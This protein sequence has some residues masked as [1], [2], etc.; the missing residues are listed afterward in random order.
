MAAEAQ[1]VERRKEAV[2]DPLLMEEI[3]RTLAGR[4]RHIRLVGRLRELYR[5][6]T[7]SQSSLIV[8]SWMAW[9]VVLDLM[10]VALNYSY[11]APELATQALLPCAIIVLGALSVITIYRGRGWL[12]LQDCALVA[13]T[14]VILFAIT[15][16]GV[17]AGPEFYE[18]YSNIMIFVAITAIVIFPIP[19]AWTWAMAATAL[20]LH[21]AMQLCSPLVDNVSAIAMSAF[22]GVGLVGTVFA[23]R[24]VTIITQKSFLLSLR[25]LK[26][27]S[28]LAVANARLETLARTDPL[29]GVANRR[30]MTETMEGLWHDGTTSRRVG[31]LMCDVDHFKGLNDALGHLEGDRCLR[32]VANVIR[33]CI[34][35]GLDHVARYGGEEFLVL[36]TDVDAFD[37]RLAAERICR[38]MEAALLP[39]PGS[40]VSRYVTVSIGVST[41]HPDHPVSAERL[42]RQAD[43]ALYL[44]KSRGRNRV[45]AYDEVLGT[46]DVSIPPSA[47]I[48]RG[49]RG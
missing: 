37:A 40:G 42:Q 44:A 46:T 2:E 33:D 13:G 8:R 25:D 28:D 11:L 43:E 19:L 4:T 14:F 9:V 32:E 39:N 31:I 15:L 38:T 23:R 18:R 41:D 21:L 5:E 36:L 7:F 27:V 3:D 30:W 1:A 35:P 12:V 10:G 22:F 49:G 6:R 24:S 48:E 16:V 47:R 34:R 45:V 29:T 26:R 20:F 17:I